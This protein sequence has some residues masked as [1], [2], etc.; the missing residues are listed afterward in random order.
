[1]KEFHAPSHV[2]KTIHKLKLF[3]AKIA[4]I[5]NME[6]NKDAQIPQNNEHESFMIVKKYDSNV[7][8]GRVGVGK[9]CRMFGDL[10]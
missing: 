8:K 10:S 1:M 7:E 3:N 4:I 5:N 9:G 2:A 6:A